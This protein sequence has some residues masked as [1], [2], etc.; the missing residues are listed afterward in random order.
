MHIEAS[1]W[2]SLW[3]PL[4]LL[5][6]ICLLH[7][8]IWKWKYFPMTVK[9]SM[10]RSLWVITTQVFVNPHNAIVEQ[11]GLGWNQ[12]YAFLPFAL[13]PHPSTIF[14]FPIFTTKGLIKKR[15]RNA[16]KVNEYTHNDLFTGWFF[17]LVPPKSLSTRT[18]TPSKMSVLTTKL[19]QLDN[20]S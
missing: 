17:S 18:G 12:K 16:R 15:K 1:H 13:S 7:F 4:S 3:I 2:D 9:A 19:K 11:I 20:T 5:N 6:K 8:Q 10:E 14:P